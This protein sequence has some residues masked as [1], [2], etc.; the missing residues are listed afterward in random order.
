MEGLKP[1]T[2]G[3]WK[4]D[5]RDRFVWKSKL[6]EAAIMADR[7]GAPL[8]IGADLPLWQRLVLLVGCEG[9]AVG[10]G[11]QVGIDI[12]PRSCGVPCRGA[13]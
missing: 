7:A 12:L 2:A 1:F 3:N 8:V 4:R 9:A 13:R 6:T 11:R 10:P 5:T